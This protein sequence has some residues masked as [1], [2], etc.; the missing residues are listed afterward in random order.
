MSIIPRH[1]FDI[2]GPAS[3]PTV[4]SDRASG[5]MTIGVYRYK[6]SYINRYGET[7][8]GPASSPVTINTGSAL[9]TNIP[10][11]QLGNVVAR[12]IYRT[13]LG[14]SAPYRL[15]G[16]IN[17]NF[18][19]T[20]TDI[21]ADTSLGATEP[22]NN[23]AS[24]VG[25]ERG[26][27]VLSR[28]SIH[29]F[30]VSITAAGASYSTATRC[31]QYG[32]FFLV[33]VPINLSG[34]VL[35]PVTPEL[36]GMLITVKNV[37]GVNQLSVYPDSLTGQINAGGAGAPRI[38]QPGVSEDFLALST[39]NWQVIATTGGPGGVTTLDG[40]ATGLTPAVPSGGAVSLGGTLVVSNGGTGFTSAASGSVIYGTGITPLGALLGAPGQLLVSG[41]GS[42]PGWTGLITYNGTTIIGIPTPNNPGDIV[43]K[44]YVD[45]LTT[46]FNVHAPVQLAS[47]TALTALYSNGVSGV[48]ATLTNNGALSP[49]QIDTT[50]ATPGMR[51]LIK[52]QAVALQNGVY[53]VSVVGTGL[54]PWVLIR[55][56]DFDNS[57][58]GEVVSGD[59]VFVETGITNAGTGWVQ[60]QVGSGGGGA[61]IV[62]VDSFLFAQFSSSG[63]Y[64]AGTGLNLAGNTFSNTGVLSV[65]G[66][67]TG[68]VFTPS[69]GNAVMSGVL[70]IANGGTGTTAGVDIVIDTGATPQYPQNLTSGVWYGIGTKAA[71]GA[72]SVRMGNN[73]S[74][75]GDGAISIGF[76]AR[77][78]G[79]NCISVGKDAGTAI[80]IGT[81]NT[82]V[83][84]SGGAALITGS[85]NVLIGSGANT[86]ASGRNDAVVLGNGVTSI[87]A[88]G[89]HDGGLYSRHFAGVV[90]GNAA[91]WVG[92]ELCESTSSQRYKENIRPLEDIT[93][94]F[95]QLEAVRYIG[96]GDVNKTEQIG[97]IAEHVEKIFPEFVVYK[98]ITGARA[99]SPTDVSADS[100][101]GVCAEP[102]ADSPTGVCAE[103]NVIPHGLVYDRMVVLLIQQVQKLTAEVEALKAGKV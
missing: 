84:T 15:I 61:L 53:N 98:E 26:W 32:E 59:F 65:S 92:N 83:G 30:D 94:R 103:K 71:G 75:T 37:S 57:P 90:T 25:V 78:N 16:T 91:V 29:P 5:N 64:V 43:N 49:L 73:A 95:M 74:A 52:N 38:L 76:A 18:T 2:E 97:M 44:G 19:T 14:G 96:K 87:S 79:D 40:G 77:A 70:N 3:A 28:P 20:F 39:T 1:G 63:A 13:A 93:S 17:D 86:D 9:L 27:T 72:N 81:D 8:A 68:F 21:D 55:A 85:G 24:G 66:G 89:A 22:V 102:R 7:L 10:I 58:V 48:G 50:P 47:T 35:P 41:G 12:K 45:G 60:T 6:V 33:N 11:H 69:S 54:V 99:D 67:T 4:E 46:G 34:V 31:S 101:T 23:F 88:A 100:P 80:T 82:I 56:S 36:V 62:G 42:A 51:V